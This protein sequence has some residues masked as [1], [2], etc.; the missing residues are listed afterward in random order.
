MAINPIFETTGAHLLSF[1][2]IPTLL[3]KK[4]SIL[5]LIPPFLNS[6]CISSPILLLV[7][8]VDMGC[9]TCVNSPVNGQEA[10]LCQK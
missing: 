10:L 4:P 5:N 3:G 8:E 6:V 2:L 1:S 9:M 7:K